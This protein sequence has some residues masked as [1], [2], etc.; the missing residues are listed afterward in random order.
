MELATPITIYW[1]LPPAPQDSCTLQ[2]IA[3]EI[4]ICRPLMLQIYC[5]SVQP[6]DALLLILK[7]L[8]SSQIAI[9]VTI[10]AGAF[11]S[12]P[13]NF[14]NESGVRE[15]LLYAES[16]TDLAEAVDTRNRAGSPASLGIS[17]SVT[18]SN[19][20]Q[21][22]DLVS[23]CRKNGII[24]LVLPM[25]RLY[26]NEAPFYI[27][28]QEQQELIGTL[29]ETGAAES[30]NLTIHDPFL[31]R[32]FN[33]TVPFPQAGCQAANTMLAIAP[34][35]GIYPCP[36]LPVRLGSIHECSLKEIIASPLKK[37]FRKSLLVPPG[38]CR[39][40]GEVAVCRGGCRGRGLSLQGTLDGLDT[41]CQ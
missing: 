19:W 13:D 7:Q 8:G 15:L 2:R 25:Q 30:L 4:S 28:R 6:P 31:W 26:N 35:G 10:P 11:Q 36:T 22:P 16:L 29:A 33:P 34:D 37:Q 3:E 20:Q 1:D 23:F 24:R 14:I 41:A 40:C 21:L 27:T 12:L 38:Q 39:D 9:S 17:Y 32:A 5:G 18:R